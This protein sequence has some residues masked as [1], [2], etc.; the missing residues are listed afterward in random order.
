[1]R[2]GHGTLGVFQCFT[3]ENVGVAMVSL[4]FPT[5]G[6]QYFFE[7]KRFHYNNDWL[8]DWDAPAVDEPAD[9]SLHPSQVT[10]AK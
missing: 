10:R 2:A 4:I 6:F 7:F 8:M 1:M 3:H 5:D 9:M